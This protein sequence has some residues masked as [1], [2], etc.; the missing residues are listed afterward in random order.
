MQPWTTATHDWKKTNV[1]RDDSLAKWIR[2]K[3]PLPMR[4]QK[5][6]NG[7]IKCGEN[8]NMWPVHLCFLAVIEHVTENKEIIEVAQHNQEDRMEEMTLGGG[9]NTETKVQGIN[10]KKMSWVN[11][12]NRKREHAKWQAIVLKNYRK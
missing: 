2:N 8:G 9:L 7:H 10:Q 3:L 5:D 12:R 11:A 1:L 6:D 4:R